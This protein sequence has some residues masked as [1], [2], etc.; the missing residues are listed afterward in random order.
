MTGTHPTMNDLYPD[1]RGY[2][3]AHEP[4][5]RAVA[6]ALTAAGFEVLDWHADPNDPRD[7][8]I[9]IR[10]VG[11]LDHDEVWIGWSEER[12]WSILRIDEQEHREPNRWVTDLNVGIVYSPW[13]VAGEVAE[14]A[15]LDFTLPDDGHPDVDFSGH[16]FDE[17]NIPLE[18]ALRHYAS[19]G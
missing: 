18:L 9:Q 19:E 11:D 15:G 17:D 7:G 14:A 1:G 10:P 12:A 13:F 5:I 16:T 2:H 3:D 4:Y 8:A 6:A